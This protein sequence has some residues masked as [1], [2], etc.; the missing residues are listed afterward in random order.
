M[1]VTLALPKGFEDPNLDPV[2]APVWVDSDGVEYKVASGILEPKVDEETFEVIEY[3]TS[4]PVLADPYRANVVVGMDGLT[5][6]N[7]MGLTMKEPTL[8]G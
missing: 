6:L 5:A 1:I 2:T 7:L 8:N 4:D 3:V